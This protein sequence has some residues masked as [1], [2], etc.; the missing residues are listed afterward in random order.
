MLISKH[1]SASSVT[2]IPIGYAVGDATAVAGGSPR[3]R[4]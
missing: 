4:D 2:R 3:C 1:A